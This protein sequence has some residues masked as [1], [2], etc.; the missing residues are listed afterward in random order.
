MPES[1]DNKA[2]YRQPMNENQVDQNNDEVRIV[3]SLAEAGFNRIFRGENSRK[4]SLVLSANEAE[5]VID[6]DGILDV[7]AN[8]MGDKIGIY[9]RI[10]DKNNE[11]GIAEVILKNL[12]GD[13]IQTQKVKI[14][15]AAGLT[16]DY[17]I[18]EEE[19]VLIQ[20]FYK[21]TTKGETESK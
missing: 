13:V 3:V 9:I 18:S 1:P 14:D 2:A 4:I 5:Q 11:K 8:P 20:V 16:L 21:P 19:N 7:T 6:Q 17:K 10:R 12:D 15:K